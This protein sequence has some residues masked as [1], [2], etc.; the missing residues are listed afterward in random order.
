LVGVLADDDLELRLGLVEVADGREVSA[1]VDDPVSARVGWQ[2]AG[3]DDRLGDGD[4]L[5][6]HR[7]A[8]RRADDAADL[9]A[10]GHRRLPPPL[11]P[12]PPPP[13]PPRIPPPSPCGASPAS[14]FSAS[15]G[16][17][18]SEWLMRYVVCARIGNSAR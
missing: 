4:V 2:E 9:V 18:A 11:A 13:P 17:A 3:E 16:I 12:P 6:H 10:D 14:R 8:G 1:L 7:G 15:R 5:V